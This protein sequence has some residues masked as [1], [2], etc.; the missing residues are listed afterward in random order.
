[1][2]LSIGLDTAVKALRAHQ[3]AVDVASHNIANAQSPG[4]SRQRVL[5]RPVGLDGSDHFSRDNLLGRAGFGVDAKDVNRIRDLFMDFQARQSMSSQSQYQALST[6]ISNAEVVFNDP[7]DEG[8]SALLGK[9]WAAWHD[10][11]NEPESSPARVALVHATTTF[12]TRLR[13]AHAELT[14]QR[15]D[16]NQSVAG[17]AEQI[18]SK[19]SELA[20]LNLQ[21]QQVELNGDMANDLRDRRDLLMDD[22]SKLGNISYAEDASGSQTV[23]LGTHELVVGTSA[24]TINTIQDPANP[25][26]VK[27]EFAI[28]NDAVS[29][30]S[31]QL[32]GVLDARDV[33]LPD[34]IAKLNTFASGL[35]NSVNSIHQAGYGLDNTTGLAFFTGT[36]A[37]NIAVNSVVAGSPQSIAAATGANQPGNPSNALAIA[38]LQQATNMLA[39]FA[40]S[41]LV[42][43]EALS[44]GNTAS[45][46][47]LA[48]SLQPGSYSLVAAGPNVELRYG[49]PTGPV[50]G[51]ATLAAIAPPGGTITFMN[52]TNTV[53]SISVSATGAY[54]A[55]QQLTDLTAAGNNT[56]Q[57]EASASTYYGNIVTVLGADVNR[58]NGL[59]DSA[60]LL[61]DHLD[62][63]RQS[64]QG[65]NIDEEVT[66]LNASQHAYNAAAKVISTIDEMLDTL[67]NR[68]GVG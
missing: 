28:D 26:M 59:A 47:T 53:A 27:L 4:Y 30:S 37:S 56:L 19:A 35:I 61:V 21:I 31:G 67:I 50:V 58:A 65:V 38:N 52:G 2:G 9:F 6:P 14:Q 7:S 55:A 44:A 42:V 46:I 23:Y 29:V 8:I 22:L 48:G 3:L 63:M 36:D 17:I 60:Q 34:L 13:A 15:A 54:S 1:M 66:N 40:A 62:G 43:N 18:N 5:L 33:A 57:V 20:S 12:T 51:T 32:K 11:T 39:G 16:L 25:G 10:V 64:V 45:G 41:S 68:T 49:G 24:R